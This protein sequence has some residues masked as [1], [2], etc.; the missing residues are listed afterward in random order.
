MAQSPVS[1]PS[2]TQIEIGVT[3]LAAIAGVVEGSTDLG[4]LPS[5]LRVTL[6]SVSGAIIALNHWLNRTATPSA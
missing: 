1:M 2:L 3:K 6:L 5:W 4:G